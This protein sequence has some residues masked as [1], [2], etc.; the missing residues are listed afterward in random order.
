MLN[1]NAATFARPHLST[2]LST[3]QPGTLS[4]RQFGAWS[5]GA[6]LAGALAA[7]RP[8]LAADIALKLSPEEAYKL[9]A[10]GNGFSLG[11]VMA[12]NP[13]Y[14]FFDTTCPHCAHL[15]QSSSPLTKQLKFVWMPVGLLRPG[16]SARQGATILSAANPAAAMQENEEKVAARQGGITVPTNLSD[17]ALAKVK[18]NTVLFDKLG[19][20]SVP[21]ILYRQQGSGRFGAYAGSAELPQL[22]QMF[23]L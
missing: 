22:R 9:A 7:A 21:L 15:W 2:D 5:A 3:A 16:V 1:V 12:A 11:P 19:A 20:D 10:G 23:G 14:V 17:E 4:R 18:A 6:A 13:V 8:A